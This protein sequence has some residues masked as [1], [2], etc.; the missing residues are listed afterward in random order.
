MILLFLW[1]QVPDTSLNV[2]GC[3]TQQAKTEIE[4]STKSTFEHGENT[5]NKEYHKKLLKKPNKNEQQRTGPTY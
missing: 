3:K 1:H 2:K 4:V 5:N